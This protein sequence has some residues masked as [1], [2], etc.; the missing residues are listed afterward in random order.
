MFCKLN[1]GLF[2]VFLTAAIYIHVG[3]DKDQLITP[4][5][6]Q[7]FEHQQIRYYKIV[8]ERRNI[9]FRGLFL[10]LILSLILILYNY[11]ILRNKLGRMSM[12]FMVGSLSLVTQ[13]FYYILSPKSDYM[14]L[15][16]ETVKQKKLWLNIYRTMTIKYHVGLLL[17]LIAS[18]FLSNSFKCD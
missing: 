6:Q 13:Y 15:H 1:A 5:V 17:G 9:Y 3:V 11:Y 18:L 8:N 4:Y 16:L 12:L 14:I 2:I 7:L 10:G